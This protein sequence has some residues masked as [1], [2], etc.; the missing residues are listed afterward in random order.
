[1]AAAHAG[2]RA[3]ASRLGGR[4]PRLGTL[5]NKIALELSEASHDG[6]HQLAARCAQVERQAMLRKH[7]DL[8]AV[9]VVEGLRQVLC[10]PAQ[11]ISSVTRIASIS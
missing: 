6:A 7:A 1:M 10:A 9:E 2:A 4:E 11:R 8:P 5:P 3:D